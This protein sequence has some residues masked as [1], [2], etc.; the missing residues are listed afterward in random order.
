MRGRAA[1]RPVSLTARVSRLERELAVAEPYAS[2]QSRG[3]LTR[4]LVGCDAAAALYDDY[5]YLRDT[6]G[7]AGALASP[8]GRAAILAVVASL[9]GL[10]GSEGIAEESGLEQVSALI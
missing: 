3:M 4:W 5:A 8:A 1:L 2:V 6:L 10:Y 9:Y 7:T